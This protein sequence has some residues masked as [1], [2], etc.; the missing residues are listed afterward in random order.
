MLTCR[1]WSPSICLRN[2]TAAEFFDPSLHVIWKWHPVCVG[3]TDPFQVGAKVSLVSEE[4][5]HV[6]RAVRLLHRFIVAT[7][8]QVGRGGLHPGN[9]GWVD[10]GVSLER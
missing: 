2:Q 8:I 10:V 9:Y 6:L 5:E 3:D 7:R 4:D 1:G